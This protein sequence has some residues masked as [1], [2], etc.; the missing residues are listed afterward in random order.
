MSYEKTFPKPPWLRPAIL[1]DYP[2]ADIWKNVS[3]TVIR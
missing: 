2:H 1:S 3:L